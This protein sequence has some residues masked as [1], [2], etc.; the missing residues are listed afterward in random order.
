[1]LGR[2]TDAAIHSLTVFARRLGTPALTTVP[3]S[4]A[5]LTRVPCVKPDQA[6]EDVAQLFIGGRNHELAVIADG[7]PI[8]VV[9]RD[10]VARGLE[11]HGPHAVVAEAP[12][13]EVVTVTPS[14]SL[15]EV[16]EELRESPERVV[17]VVDHGD[18]VGLLTLDRLAAY[19]E[20]AKVA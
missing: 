17:V 6:L 2:L 19:V 11:R 1:M 18:P 4:A 20:Q 15:A 14:D 5:M 3:V 8:G 7:H 9:T 16:L 13:H 10:D 12:Q